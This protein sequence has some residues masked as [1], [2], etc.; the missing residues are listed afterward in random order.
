MANTATSQMEMSSQSSSEPVVIERTGKKKNKKKKYS[1]A[2][3]FGQ[4]AEV[5]LS[6]GGHRLAN[7]VTDGLWAWR[8]E[9]D[10]SARNKRDGAIRDAFKNYGRS[11]SRFGREA[12][13]IP[14]DITDAFPKFSKLFR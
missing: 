8:R 7:A 13:R 4:K 3:G 5:A 6:K 1:R 9:R 14:E 2:F 10:K 11:M 12:A